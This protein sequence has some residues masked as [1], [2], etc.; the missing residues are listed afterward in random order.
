MTTLLV[1]IRPLIVIIGCGIMLEQVKNTRDLKK[2]KIE[3]KKILAKEI[4]EYIIDI[5]SKLL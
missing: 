5:V 1:F 2:L 4:R 3:D